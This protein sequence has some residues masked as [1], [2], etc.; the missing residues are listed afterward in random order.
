MEVSGEAGLA[1]LGPAELV[2][3]NGWR[4]GRA[5]NYRSGREKCAG[6]PREMP[7]NAG[8][9]KGRRDASICWDRSMGVTIT[10]NEKDRFSVLRKD[11]ECTL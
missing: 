2:C 11:Q 6:L 5:R 3:V 4:A 7:E 9:E 8:A 1:R 10:A